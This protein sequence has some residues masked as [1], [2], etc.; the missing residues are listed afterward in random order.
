MTHKL[1]KLEGSEIELTITVT[2]AEYE[3]HTKKAIQRIS[4]KKALKGFRKGHAPNDMIKKEFG[5]MSI[6]QEAL[7]DIIKDTF[8]QVIKLEKLET[9]G[10]PKI[11]IEKLAPG[12]EIVYKAVVGLMPKVK[13]A[14]ISKIKVEVKK[15]AVKVRRSK[16]YYL[17][18]LTGREAVRV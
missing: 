16:L 17:R 13:L 6:L 8:Y 7:E 4:E 12:N 2:P 9:I 15:K 11:D 14:N 18:N 5:E 10:M 1:K 3:K